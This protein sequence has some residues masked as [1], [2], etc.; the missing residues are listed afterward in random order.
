MAE[1]AEAKPS[2]S[3]FLLEGVGLSA[4]QLDV[5]PTD[6]GAESGEVV[7]AHLSC[8]DGF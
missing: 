2:K 5:A 3:R 7:R 4:P 8:V 1:E 6:H